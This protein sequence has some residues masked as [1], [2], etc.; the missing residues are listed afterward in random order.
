MED[1]DRFKFS[2]VTSPDSQFHNQSITFIDPRVQ[3]GTRPI[4]YLEI[5][6]EQRICGYMED[7]KRSRSAQV[8]S[9]QGGPSSLI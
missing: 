3:S 4:M 6:A 5:N 2:S 9:G 1:L 8:S 7:Q